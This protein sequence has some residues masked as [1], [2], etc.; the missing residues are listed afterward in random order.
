MGNMWAWGQD[1]SHGDGGCESPGG[2]ENGGQLHNVASSQHL[3]VGYPVLTL[4]IYLW[5]ECWL[6]L[7]T[8]DGR[9]DL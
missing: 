3:E 7:C 6:D 8:K 1:T 2:P 5:Q 9:G 4:L